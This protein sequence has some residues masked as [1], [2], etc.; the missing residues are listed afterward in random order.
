M[1][2]SVFT[3]VASLNAQRNLGINSQGLGKALER[4]SSGMRINRASD[5]AAGLAISTGLTS[6]INGLNQA[7][8]NAGDGLSMMSIAESAIK[9]QS[10]LLQRMREL[11]VQSANDTNSASN[12]KA[13]NDEVTQL[14]AEIDRIAVTVE[15]NGIKLLDG[16]FTSKELQVGS[17]AGGTQRIGVDF[18]STRSASMGTVHRVASAGAVTNAGIAD[19]DFS[20]VIDGQTYAVDA[21]TSDGVST[22][23]ATKSAIAYANAVN[24]T[25]SG[26]LATATAASGTYTQAG[27]GGTTVDGGA[28]N[29]I[30][31]NGV[32]LGNIGAIADNTD[33][34]LRDAINAK[35]DETGVTASLSG[36]TLTLTNEDGRN[37]VVAAGGSGATVMG[38][39]SQIDRGGVKLQANKS[40]S[41]TGTTAMLNV[42]ATSSTQDTSE[43]IQT[44][45]VSTKDAANQAIQTIDAALSELNEKASTIGAKTNRLNSVIASLSATSENLTASKSRVMD[46]DFAAETAELTRTQILQQAATAVLAQA[47]QAPQLALSLLR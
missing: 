11:A 8:R 5:D 44:Q 6:Q 28:T 26:V 25:G 39:G 29:Y 34:D 2:L 10:S 32:N 42:A 27:D 40:F 15:F 37:I 4:L 43:T 22:S 35:T 47:N 45:T 12:R 33:V 13:L 23:E 21:A 36:G 17:Q 30:T 18:S 7:V 20:I 46:A 38:T 24:N 41:L 31:I 16:S 9:E 3:N 14:K 19:G 1:A